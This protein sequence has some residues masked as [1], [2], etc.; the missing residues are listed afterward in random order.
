[1]WVFSEVGTT[2]DGEKLYAFTHRTFMEY[3]AAGDLAAIS[4]TP[5]S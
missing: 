3:F 2:A 5:V 4:D 1:M